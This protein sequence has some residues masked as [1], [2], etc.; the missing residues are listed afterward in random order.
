MFNSLNGIY[1]NKEL[2]IFWLGET[3][4]KMPDYGQAQ[5]NTKS[6]STVIQTRLIS[7]KRT[8]L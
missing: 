8:I 1:E 2:L 5:T 3:Y 4:L 7:H 6:L